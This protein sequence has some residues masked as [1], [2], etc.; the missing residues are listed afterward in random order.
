MDSQPSAP[1]VVAVVVAAQQGPW[2]E[3]ALA[4]LGA[5]DYPNQP[6]LVIDASGPESRSGTYPGQQECAQRV[7][8]VL[9]DAYL[10]RVSAKATFATIANDALHTVQG[11]SFLLFC[12]DDV[13]PD[14]DAVRLMVEEA[15]RSNAGIVGPKIVRW[16]DP[17]RLLDVGLAVDKTGAAEP[18]ADRDEL[19]QEQHDSVKDAFAVSWACM[20]V[21]SDLFVALRGFDPAMGD[22]GAD[23]DLCWRAQVAGARVMVA[24]AARVRHLEGGIEAPPAA[25]ETL[26]MEA[27]NRLRAMLKS[28]S[29]LHLVRVIPQA[30]VVTVVEAVVA[31]FTRHRGEASALLS[32]WWWNFRHLG[33]LRALRRE[34]KKTRAV[35]DSE[36]RRLQV[37]GSVRASSFI[38]HRI[39]PEDRARALVDAGHHLAGAVER[40]PARIAAVVLGVLLLGLLFGSRHLIGSP[41][42]AVGEF[43][44]VP[45]VGSLFSQFLHGWRTTGMG[46][47]SSV[48]PVLGFLGLGGVALL[49]NVALLQK[50]LVLAAIPVGG[51]G[52]WYLARRLGSTLGRLVLTVAYLAVPLPYNAIANGRWGGLVAYAAAPW[53]LA[54][55]GRLSRLVPFVS[56]TEADASPEPGRARLEL[57]GFGL[58]LAPVVAFVPS[59]GLAL[60]L[61]AAGLVIGSLV[62][63]GAGRA[64]RGLVTAALALGVGSVLLFPWSLDLL[65]GQDWTTIAGV[66]R[67]PARALGLGALLRFQVGP[68]GAAPL[69][70]AIL[71]AAVLPLVVGQGWRFAWAVRFWSVALL[72]ILV[73]WAGGHDWLPLRLQSPEVLLA[74]AAIAFA[75]AAAI[76]ATAYELDIRAYRFGWRQVAFLGAGLALILGTLPILSAVSSGRWGLTARDLS[77]SVSWMSANASQGAF[78]VLW[79]GDPDALPLAGWRLTDGI[80]YATSRNGPPVATDNLPGPPSGATLQMRDALRQATRGNTSRLGRLL[81]PMAVRYIVIP[82]AR[83][84]GASSDALRAL[85][86][87][88]ALSRALGSQLDLRLLPSDPASVVYE[89]T[90]WGPGRELLPPRTAAEV[91]VLPR[92]LGNGADLS[93]G[94]PV[95]P[96]RGPVQ[97]EGRLDATGQVLVSES[98][99]SQWKLS[100]GGGEAP[101]QSAFG[102]ANSYAVSQPGYAVLSFKT[103]LVRYGALLVEVGIWAIAIWMVLRLRRQQSLPTRQ[104]LSDS[105][106]LVEPRRVEAPT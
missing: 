1:P 101:R 35:P 94:A 96:G 32:A 79:V 15:L 16:E 82:S 14:P 60:L 51:L 25:P 18:L 55:L 73:A 8:S 100:A 102:V 39:H 74:P 38:R 23:I 49:G 71:L 47:V 77:R 10:R 85:A 90:V 78:R 12:H 75:A 29:F 56:E 61:T 84:T 58:V 45:G 91:A 4:A 53:L 98:P 19:D 21:R 54:R 20:L 88:P 40:G 13:A 7:A 87:P 9:P 43:A 41:I 11:S 64:A 76:G 83:G 2:F 66:G 93:G 42:P 48:P 103:P 81:A 3:E 37:R 17:S 33:E 46:S 52:A 92:E 27:R 30:A 104:Y 62:V 50:I 26:R 70:W 24:P 86:A 89:N 72:C 5:Q 80:A 65:L 68:L 69:G 95:L 6:V 22:H 36:V 44:P 97:Y 67:A 57:I 31:I 99:S 59:I 105:Q 28:Y 34:V 63:G 106:L